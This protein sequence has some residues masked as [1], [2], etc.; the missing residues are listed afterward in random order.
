M[1]FG[2]YDPCDKPFPFPPCHDL[3]LHQG[4]S[5]CRAGDHNSP[6][7]LVYIYE[8]YIGNFPHQEILAK[9]TLGRR[10]KFSVVFSLFQG[11]AMKMYSR[12]YFSLWKYL[13]ISGRSQTQLKLN[14]R[15][16]LPIY[17]ILKDCTSRM[18]FWRKEWRR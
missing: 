2:M 17:D 12:V 1:I 14:P 16:K 18:M 15:K 7:L 8:P 9:R 11:L 5:C 10:V 4:Q 3:D 13:A 6:N